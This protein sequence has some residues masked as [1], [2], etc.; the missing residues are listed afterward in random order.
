MKKINL[1]QRSEEWRQYRR[2]K[3]G[4]SDAPVIMDI[5]PYKTKYQ[6][7]KEKIDGTNKVV[8]KAMQ[9]GNDLESVGRDIASRNHNMEFQPECFE[10][11]KYPWMFAS[12]DGWNEENHI[13]LEVKCPKKEFVMVCNVGDVPADYLWQLIHNMCVTK[14]RSGILLVYHPDVCCDISITPNEDETQRLIEAE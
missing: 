9:R 6:L 5:S 3:I 4:G 1:E 13:V 10:S 2:N 11:L 12:V 14:A 7:W 8:T